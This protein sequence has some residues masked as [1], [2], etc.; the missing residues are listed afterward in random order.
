[1]AGNDLKCFITWTVQIH[2]V[3]IC[4]SIF[5]LQEN[6]YTFHTFTFFSLFVCVMVPFLFRWASLSF[7]VKTDFC[8]YWQGIERNVSHLYNSSP[9]T[10][11]DPDWRGFLA[12]TD[13]TSTTVIKLL[14]CCWLQSVLSYSASQPLKKWSFLGFWHFV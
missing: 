10:V 8:K 14:V 7:T 4:S 6:K 9:A 12:T 5:V 3:D 1:M 2:L 11:T 13:V